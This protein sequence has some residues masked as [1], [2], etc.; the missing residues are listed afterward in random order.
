MRLVKLRGPARVRPR[1]ARGCGPL[2]A[3]SGAAAASR[4]ADG[5]GWRGHARG[6][7]VS[8]WALRPNGYARRYARDE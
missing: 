6:L 1:W 4:L 8:P 7:R 2:G 5:T 3:A